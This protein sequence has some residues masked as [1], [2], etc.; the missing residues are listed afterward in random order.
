ML[1]R[2][3]ALIITRWFSVCVAFAPVSL[4]LYS[5]ENNRVT[6]SLP[7]EPHPE[8]GAIFSW[9]NHGDHRTR[10]LTEYQHMHMAHLAAAVI[11]YWLAVC[12][13]S[14]LRMGRP[15]PLSWSKFAYLS[16]P[17]NGAGLAMGLGAVASVILV[18]T[19]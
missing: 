8:S 4:L 1:G 17:A 18:V 6:G 10:Y 19:S 5:Y 7:L 9:S 12:I 13:A 14:W 3:E 15:A 11:I 2:L 16:K